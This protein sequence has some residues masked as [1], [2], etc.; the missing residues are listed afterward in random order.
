MVGLNLGST[1][2]L[3]TSTPGM[4]DAMRS[5]QNTVD[6]VYHFGHDILEDALRRQQREEDG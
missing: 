3:V 6:A 4:R 5:L 1:S 2:T